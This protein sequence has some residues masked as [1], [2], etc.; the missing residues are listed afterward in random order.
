[1][2]CSKCGKEFPEGITV[3][4]SCESNNTQPQQF[5]LPQEPPPYTQPVYT[6]PDSMP[7]TNGLAIASL[8]VSIVGFLIGLGIVAVILG[9][10]G[11]NQIKASL[12]RQKGSG[13]AIAGIVVGCIGAVVFVPLIL[14]AVLFPVFN[15]ARMKA[16]D[17]MCLQNLKE[18]SIA[19]S[20]YSQDYNEKL[21]PADKWSD[22]VAK[23]ITDS[24]VFC[25]GAARE[26]SCA[27]SFNDRLNKT[28]L[29]ELVNAS[30][31]PMLFDSKGGWNS[32]LPI[33]SFDARHCGGYNCSFADGHVKWVLPKGAA[34]TGY[35]RYK[36]D[37]NKLND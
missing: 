28:S 1:M 17:T 27:Y 6:D 9:I 37:D 25:C 11:Q 36:T 2:F 5:D 30:N 22:A 12:G 15:T 14:A 10:I 26:L 16:R 18:L 21:P 24:H 35:R 23:Y 8:V 33:S 4:E 7:K 3:C 13:L 19:V 34:P 29:K 32:A 20:T 31:A